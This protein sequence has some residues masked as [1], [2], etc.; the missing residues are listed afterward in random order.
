M[1]TLLEKVATEQEFKSFEEDLPD[2]ERLTFNSYWILI[3]R[4]GIAKASFQNVQEIEQ[5]FSSKAR[6][7]GYRHPTTIEAATNLYIETEVGKKEEGVTF[8]SIKMNKEPLWFVL[9][10][11]MFY[12]S[13]NPTQCLVCLQDSTYYECNVRAVRLIG[14]L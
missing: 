4:A 12:R 2:Q 10:R 6:E 9:G 1:R 3:T 7:K 13:G 5:H 11:D 14:P 8:C